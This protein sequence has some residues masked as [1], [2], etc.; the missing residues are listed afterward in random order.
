MENTKFFRTT[1][2]NLENFL[3]MHKIQFFSQEKMDDGFNCWV[4]LRTENFNRVFSEYNALK[5]V[6]YMF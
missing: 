1:N 4:Y 2:R 6:N 5:D 3:H